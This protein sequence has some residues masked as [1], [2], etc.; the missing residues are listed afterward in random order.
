MTKSI[1]TRAPLPEVING[2]IQR[3]DETLAGRKIVSER[4][5]I[6]AILGANLQRAAKVDVA[7]ENGAEQPLPIAAIRLE[8]RQRK[9]CF[10]A[11]AGAG[12]ELSLYY[13]DAKLPVPMY[14]YER[15]FV[16]SR[17]AAVAELS[18]EQV[19]PDFVPAPMAELTLMQRHPEVLWMVLIA[20]ACA[21]GMVGLRS[22][23]NV[24]HP[25]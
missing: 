22:A 25:S 16:T 7:I 9:I 11:A 21:I 19:N 18:P 24:G 12:S 20:V 13:G 6:A 23:R 5:G 3:V 4:L 10:D 8:M 1:R 14:G 17:E 2:M 15:L